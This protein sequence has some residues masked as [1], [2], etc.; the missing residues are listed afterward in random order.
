MNLP[1]VEGA[2]SISCAKPTHHEGQSSQQESNSVYQQSV[3]L[4]VP[5]CVDHRVLHTLDQVVRP[6][7][8]PQHLEDEDRV[9]QGTL[10]EARIK[11]YCEG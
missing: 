9:G 6:A 3:S 4:M 7:R 1:V 8:I 5:L 10:Y 11:R 2:E